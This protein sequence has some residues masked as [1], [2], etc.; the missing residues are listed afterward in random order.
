MRY[1]E[2]EDEEDDTDAPGPDDRDLPDPSDTDTPGDETDDTVPCP[3]CG[4]EVYESAERCPH[5]GSY[6]SDE[7]APR[8]RRP[9]WLVAG[10]VLCLAIVLL[11]WVLSA[12]G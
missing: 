7:D 8:R 6:V 3:Y 5:C 4:R 2:P 1:D 9:W 10:V 11:A 12:N